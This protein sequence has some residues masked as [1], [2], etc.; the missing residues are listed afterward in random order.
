VRN[1]ELFDRKAPEQTVSVTINSD[2]VAKLR[3]TDPNISKIAEAALAEAYRRHLR[4]A[5]DR[6]IDREL[7]WIEG[8]TA[9]LGCS[10]GEALDQER[11]DGATA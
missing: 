10:F 5:A 7:A 1:R 11:V 6:E 9:E 2:L 8:Y 3:R 4:E